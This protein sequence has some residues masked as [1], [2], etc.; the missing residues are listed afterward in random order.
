MDG[1]AGAHRKT[2]TAFLDESGNT[3]RNYLDLNQPFYTSGGW[4]IDE[5]IQ[6]CCADSVFHWE[7][8]HLRCGMHEVKAAAVLAKR[9]GPDSVLDLIEELINLGGLPAFCV[10]EKSFGVCAAIV[11]SIWGRQMHANY[12]SLAIKHARIRNNIAT[13]LFKSLSSKTIRS[14]ALAIYQSN[15]GLFREAHRSMRNELVQHGLLE[16]CMRAEAVPIQVSTSFAF[17][18]NKLE[19]AVNRLVFHSLLMMLEGYC[20]KAG[21]SRWNIIHDD[22]PSME[23][24]FRTVI[25]LVESGSGPEVVLDNGFT[26]YWGPLRLSG[27][28]FKRSEEEPLVRAADFLTGYM[29]RLFGRWKEYGHT[30]SKR[31]ALLKRITDTKSTDNTPVIFLTLGPTTEKHLATFLRTK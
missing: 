29:N 15:E 25:R 17:S 9:D 24:E 27:I 4:I 13:L 3:G 20:R 21:Y 31:K 26:D 5:Y 10:F 2:Y 30:L 23:K 22:I 8:Q 7:Q 12:G 14:F 16:L 6:R 1:L 11:E 18:K 28:K 19:N